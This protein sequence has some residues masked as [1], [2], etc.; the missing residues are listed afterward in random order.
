MLRREY[1]RFTNRVSF[2]WF[3]D[4]SFDQML[5]RS[6]KLPPHSFMLFILLMRDAT[7]VTHNADEALRRIHEV[8]NAPVNGL[9]QNQLGMG[10]VG[11]QS[12]RGR[13]R[14]AGVSSGLPSRILR[15]E[16]AS[17]FPPR[18]VP[19]Q[20]APA[21][22]GGSCSGGTSA[23]IGCRPAALCD[24]GEPTLWELYRLADR[25]HGLVLPP[26]SRLDRWFAGEPRATPPGGSGGGTARR[27]FVEVCESATR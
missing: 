11:G 18:V 27:Y 23:R 7:G 4:L 24:S 6:A 15:G 1:E 26:P 20:P 12:V 10:I 19:P 9:F 5:E 3:N 8:A 17:S 14:R 2:T 21:S 13:R 16:A 22:T 25:R